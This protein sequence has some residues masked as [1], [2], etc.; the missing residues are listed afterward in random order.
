MQ[1]T[2]YF[3]IAERRVKI[4]KVILINRILEEGFQIK[5]RYYWYIPIK[6]TL[7]TSP[8][9]GIIGGILCNMQNV[10]NSVRM[11]RASNLKKFF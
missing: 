3:G 6:E 11:Q 7:N 5:R 2:V 9:V 8:V 10:T 1:I 4:E